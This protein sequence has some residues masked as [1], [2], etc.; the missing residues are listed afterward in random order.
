MIVWLNLDS[1]ISIVT[2]PSCIACW[3]LIEMQKDEKITKKKEMELDEEV[4]RVSNT[5]ASQLVSYATTDRA[6]ACLASQSGTGC[7]ISKP[8][9]SLTF[10]IFFV[11]HVLLLWIFMYQIYSL[12]HMCDTHHI[13]LSNP[14]LPISSPYIITNMYYL[15]I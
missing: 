10:Y 11:N 3:L 13:F 12:F 8:L 2:S 1:D 6:V 5:Q 9:W 7:G 15:T 4:K 14:T